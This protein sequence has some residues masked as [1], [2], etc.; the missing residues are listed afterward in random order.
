MGSL[1]K[2]ETQYPKPLKPSGVLEKFSYD[3]ST[4]AI[5]REFNNVNIVDDIIN[6]QNA[7]ELIR[8]L[9][10]TIAQRGVVF[11][12]AQNNLTDDQQKFLIQRLGELTGKPAESSLHVHPILNETSE[13]G[14][15]DRHISTINSVHRKQV[16]S[17]DKDANK[18]SQQWHSDI[19]FENVPPDFSS[20][21]LTLLPKNGGDTLWVSGYHIYD[22]LSAPYQK[23]LEG[24]TA[25]YIANGLLFHNDRI[26]EGPR[27]NPKNVGKTFT[28]VH[29]VVRTNP[30]TGWKSIYAAAAFP[31]YINELN[32]NESQAT[33]KLLTQ[34]LVENH[35]FQ[36]RFKWKNENDFAI[37]DNRSTFHT[38]THDYDRLGER[39][40]HRA[41]GIAEVPYLDPNSKSRR[42]DLYG[43][44]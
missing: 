1:G 3:D 18:H 10:I 33:I 32:E 8:D 43:E 12:R 5:G 2:S 7:D 41:V 24:L 4:P 38:A 16:Y 44:V 37:W 17:G 31:K 40:G 27:G 39:D 9:G 19:Q 20:L 26:F 36:V 21:R 23:F 15:G 34:T 30:V 25:T 28:A 42:E 35:D 13:F 29:P 6:A 14:V 11:F 22:R